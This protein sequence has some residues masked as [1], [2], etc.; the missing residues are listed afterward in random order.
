MKA[1]EIYFEQFML[2]IDNLDH[3][4]NYIAHWI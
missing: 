1:N 2:S 3:T 4:R